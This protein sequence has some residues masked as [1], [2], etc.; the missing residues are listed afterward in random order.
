M[1]YT[2]TGVNVDQIIYKMCATQINSLFFL[3]KNVAKMSIT[4]CYET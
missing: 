2:I 4:G 1:Q 3:E